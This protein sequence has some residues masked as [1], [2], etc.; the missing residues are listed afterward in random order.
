[1]TVALK[2]AS[3]CW[4][5]YPPRPPPKPTGRWALAAPASD[6]AKTTTARPASKIRRLIVRI[7]VCLLG[8][9]FGPAPL[10]GRSASRREPPTQ[11]GSD[12]SPLFIR[13][14]GQPAIRRAAGL[15]GACRFGKLSPPAAKE[16]TASDSVSRSAGFGKARKRLL[17]PFWLSASST[18]GVAAARYPPTTGPCRYP[19]PGRTHRRHSRR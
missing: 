17:E 13:S 15:R 4:P 9:P 18:D 3:A 5:P 10:P 2:S 1:M 19:S 7:Y 11:P 14:R 16:L 12:R 8:L 6:S